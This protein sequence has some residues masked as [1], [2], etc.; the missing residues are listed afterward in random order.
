MILPNPLNFDTLSLSVFKI[1]RH[2]VTFK[3]KREISC[4]QTMNTALESHDI[5]F[6]TVNRDSL[7]FVVIRFTTDAVLIIS[8][9]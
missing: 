6:V 1:N 8:A 4:G 5:R 2:H 9:D 7:Y 3:L